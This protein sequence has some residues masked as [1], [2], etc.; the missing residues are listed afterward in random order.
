MEKDQGA[1][2]YQRLEPSL[3]DTPGTREQTG[4]GPGGR[5]QMLEAGQGYYIT[6]PTPHHAALSRGQAHPEGDN[7]MPREL[8]RYRTRSQR[9]QGLLLGR[10]VRRGSGFLLGPRSRFLLR[11]GPRHAADVGEQAA[12]GH[13][14]Q[15]LG[16]RAEVP[17][18]QAHAVGRGQPSRLGCR[19][20]TG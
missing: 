1:T 12:A 11:F 6:I 17:P 20:P 5:N 3:R 19:K 2:G 15:A 8:H 10:R 14:V 16:Q 18:R 4:T 13:Y 9:P 7:K